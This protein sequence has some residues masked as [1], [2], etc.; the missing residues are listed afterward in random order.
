M[1]GTTPTFLRVARDAV[2]AVH[3]FFFFFSSAVVFWV[4]TSGIN[5][6]QYLY[7]IW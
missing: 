2:E 4:E 1:S 6:F 7:E 3:I 5:W